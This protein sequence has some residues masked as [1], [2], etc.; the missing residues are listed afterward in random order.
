VAFHIIAGSGRQRGR[1]IGWHELLPSVFYMAP[2]RHLLLT[3]MLHNSKTIQEPTKYTSTYT[4]VDRETVTNC[5]NTIR[6][7][8]LNYK[9]L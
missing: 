4:E 5:G 1:A 3:E 8:E 9:A 2:Q 7:N 6:R